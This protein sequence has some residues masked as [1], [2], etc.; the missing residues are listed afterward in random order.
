MLADLPAKASQQA[1]GITGGRISGLAHDLSHIWPRSRTA[2]VR[3]L[4]ASGAEGVVP[5]PEA[6]GMATP[7]VG[8][9]RALFALTPTMR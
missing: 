9:P 1:S 4:F 3:L 7:C 8:P 2:A 5:L 6:A